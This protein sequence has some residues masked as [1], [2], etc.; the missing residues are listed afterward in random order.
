MASAAAN[1]QNGLT[2][3]NGGTADDFRPRIL[4]RP[5]PKVT[6]LKRPESSSANSQAQ[7]AQNAANRTQIKSLEQREKE[8]AE[9]RLRI[10]G[11]ATEPTTTCDEFPPPSG[12]QQPPR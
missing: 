5:S 12:N 10:L 1:Q 4:Q 6:I 2:L 11:S 3:M 9:A 7:N 8:Y